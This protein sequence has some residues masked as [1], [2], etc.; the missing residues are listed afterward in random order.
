MIGVSEGGY[1]SD[2]GSKASVSEFSAEGIALAAHAPLETTT[3]ILEANFDDKYRLLKEEYDKRIEGLTGAVKEVCG[4]LLA[5]EV[6]GEMRSDRVSSSFVPA[7]LAEVIEACIRSDRS[8]DAHAT[9]KRISS[10]ELSLRKTK[11]GNALLTQRVSELEPQ[12]EQASHDKEQHENMVVFLRKKLEHFERECSRLAEESGEELDA[13]TGKLNTLTAENQQLRS[14]YSEA[15]QRL[16][17]QVHES[18]LLRA[19]FDGR[20]REVSVLERSCEETMREL[21]MLEASERRERSQNVEMLEQQRVLAIQRDALKQELAETSSKLR[22]TTDELNRVRATHEAREYEEDTGRQ[23]L[24][25]LMS[26]VEHMVTAEANESQAAVTALHSKMKQLKHRYSV[27]LQRERRVTASLRDELVAIKAVRDDS[28]R[29]LRTSSDENARLREG[30]EEERRRAAAATSA[31]RQ[32]LDAEQLAVAAAAETA[33]R[34]REA[35]SRLE[36]TL[37]LKEQEVRLAVGQAKL[38]TERRLD[39]ETSRLNASFSQANLQYQ[40]E[41]GTIRASFGGPDAG[42]NSSNLDPGILNNS[43]HHHSMSHLR[44]SYASGEDLGLLNSS[45]TR[46]SYLKSDYEALDEA[47][48]LEQAR[49]DEFYR[50]QLDSL[51]SR[52]REAG[53]H[54]ERLKT[55]VVERT[56]QLGAV[57]AQADHTQQQLEEQRDQARHQPGSAILELQAQVPFYELLLLDSMY[58]HPA[59]YYPILILVFFFPISL[60]ILL[61]PPLIGSPTNSQLHILSLLFIICPCGLID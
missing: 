6:V 55:M 17:A 11:E 15:C 7:H 48:K 44:H 16:E 45:T 46:A 52:L 32:S 59:I 28:L 40:N 33:A 49:N 20:G 61:H 27:D 57:Q 43:H 21:D 1:L 26:Q 25:S 19:H 14:S 56:A 3:R 42:V 35:E 18:E 54:I 29:E 9:L 5:D 47:H 24:A 39:Q 36:E 58:F 10:L 22:Y 50:L 37:A 2:V 23:R 13:L 38:E 34:Q 31:A 30:M 8:K 60:I 53:A 12:L 41:L 51:R 4:R